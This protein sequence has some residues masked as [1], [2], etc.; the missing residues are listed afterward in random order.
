MN[1]SLSLLLKAGD[2]LFLNGAVIRADRKVRIEVLNDAVFLLG[3]HLLQPEDAN[4]PLRQLYFAIQTILVEPENAPTAK[5]LAL[6]I[7]RGLLE[8]F[9]NREVLSG[10]FDVE[11]EVRRGKP[12]QALKRL[13]SLYELE[14]GILNMNPLEKSS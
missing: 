2:R 1:S 6:N 12:Y 4:T 14:A 10:L 9:S 8:A 5:A 11:H 7:I 3:S 13:R